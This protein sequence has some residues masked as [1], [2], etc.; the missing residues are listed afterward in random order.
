M[1]NIFTSESPIEYTIES[2]GS[3]ESIFAPPPVPAVSA[4]P[5]PEA[6]SLSLALSVGDP[7]VVPTRAAPARTGV[8]GVLGSI[9]IHLAP[10]AAE[11][12][13]R[14]LDARLADH[15][16]IVRRA[17]WT[18]AVSVLVANRK[19]GAGKTPV[20]LLLGG[21]FASIRGGSV[22]VVEVADDPGALAFRAEGS[23]AIGLGELVESMGRVHTAG[24]LA[25]YTA[26][27][28]SF[29]SVIGTVADRRP[30]TREDVVGVSALI[31]SFYS[32]RV[33]DSGNQSSSPAFAGA[34]ETADA[35]V[36]PVFD[37]GD[38]VVEAVS[39]LD[40]LRRQ[41]R[42]AAGLAERAVILRLDDGRPV[43]P[44]VKERIDHVIA[45]SGVPHVFSVPYDAH[46]A[47]RGQLTLGRLAPETY[48]VFAA[49][50]AAIVESA[51]IPIV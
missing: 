44:Q 28:T 38:A 33:M 5:L 30:L 12:A 6:D 45:R 37:S 1:P 51:Q 48:R 23:P 34:L 26:P 7:G 50:A 49:A 15:E 27:Q 16:G 36:I 41:G 4:P 24:Q 43:P 20:S 32:I 10:S 46:I 22:C 42:R 11:Q 14:E 19:G 13:Q 29:A 25:G 17:T 40:R 21:T 47:E 35:L 3:R 2:R 18:R 39:L 31:D 8:R 9:G